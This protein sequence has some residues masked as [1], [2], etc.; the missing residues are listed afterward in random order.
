MHKKVCGPS[1]LPMA[2]RLIRVLLWT[3]ASFAC[4]PPCVSGQSLYATASAGGSNYQGEL[5]D[6]AVNLNGSRL[7]LGAGLILAPN[8]RFHLGVEFVHAMLGGSDR[9]N[10]FYFSRRRNLHFDT[11]ISEWSLTGRLNLKT[12]NELMAIPYLTAGLALFKV[13]PF[14][15]DPSGH[16]AYLFPL[17]TEGQGL[18]GTDVPP[19]RRT[20]LSIPIGGGLE[21]RLT[22]QLRLD[23]ELAMR[24]TFTDYIDDVGN[25]YPD[26]AALMSQRGQTAVELSYRGDELPGGEPMFPPE[27]TLRGNPKSKDWYYFMQ[28]RFRYP[29]FS[30]TYRYD[31][32]NHLFKGP[33]WPYRN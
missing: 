8:D 28:L 15:T 20:N 16:R 11:R 22:R 3:L 21:L 14:T 30:R 32:I 4:A 26:G 29:I 12:G 23:I 2:S 33:D 18:S 19:H 9:Y 6:G 24:K 17:S 10:R 25:S 1:P 5:K 13:D 27:G 7:A 31:R